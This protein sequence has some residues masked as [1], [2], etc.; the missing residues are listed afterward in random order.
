M[1]QMNANER[2]SDQ[3]SLAFIC[4]TNPFF[5][6]SAHTKKIAHAAMRGGVHREVSGVGG[7]DCPLHC[8]VNSLSATSGFEQFVGEVDLDIW[9]EEVESDTKLVFSE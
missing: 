2:K 5:T 8:L 1:P 6:R 9:V 7:V 4:G 3:R